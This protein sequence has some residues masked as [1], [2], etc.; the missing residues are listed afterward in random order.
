[1]KKS[2]SGAV[3]VAAGILISRLAGLLRESLVAHY[4]GNSAIA[5]VFRAAQR[6]PNFLQNLF[7]EGSLSA[8][9]IPVY[10]YLLKQEEKQARAVA[11]TIFTLLFLMVAVLVALGVSF[12]TVFIDLIVPGFEGE[13]RQ[14][15]IDLVRIMFFG[16]GVL[17]LSAWCLGIQNSHRRFFLS[18]FAP[19]LWNACI[20]FGLFYFGSRQSQADLAYSAAWCL[21]VGCFLQFLIQVPTT[22]RLL[23]GIRFRFLVKD[24]NVKTISRNFLPAVMGRGVVQVSAYMDSM[25]TSFIGNGSLAALTCAQTVYLLPVSLFGMSIAAAELPTM[26]EGHESLSMAEHLSNRLRQSLERVAFYIYPSAFA[27]LFLGDA[28]VGLI[29]ESGHFLRKDTITV[30][31]ILGAYGIGLIPNVQSRLFSTVFFALR[32]TK[33]TFYT[34]LIRVVLSTSLGVFFC[35]Y[36]FKKLDISVEQKTMGLAMA[37]T[38]GAFLEWT[39]LKWNLRKVGVVVEQKLIYQLQIC[40]CAIAAC[41][42]GWICKLALEHAPRVVGNFSVLVSFA[43]TYFLVAHYFKVPEARSFINKVKARFKK[44]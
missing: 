12:S 4:F 36:L 13:K 42:A 20:I 9:F 10:S 23:G 7:G 33:K 6:I 14:M 21:V 24:P 35:F 18:Y 27:F 39:L 2:K 43:I 41:I 1:M 34:S 38:I 44:A 25:L 40:G 29:Y 22:Y 8:S 32:D 17:V 19:V 28:V 31:M 16:T 26:S 15:S 3:F 5:D 37:A 30:W 11:Q